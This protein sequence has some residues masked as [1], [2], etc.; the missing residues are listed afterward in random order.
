M[1]KCC[2]ATGAAD[3]P[4]PLFDT[5]QGQAAADGATESFWM[6]L[7]GEAH[8]S[9]PDNSLGDAQLVQAGPVMQG[10]HVLQASQHVCLPTIM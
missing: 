6:Q 3:H 9:G 10:E 1:Y 7:C 2:A 4:S 5:D 8:V